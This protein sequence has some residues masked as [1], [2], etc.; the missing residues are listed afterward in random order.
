MQTFPA[1][2]LTNLLGKGNPKKESCFKNL[3]FMCPNLHSLFP[4]K[5]LVCKIVLLNFNSGCLG[6]S[7]DR[8]MWSQTR[9][10][11]TPAM[12]CFSENTTKYS[13]A[14]RKKLYIM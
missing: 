10:P 14:N 7:Y 9:I 2:D 6:L 11:Q 4:V 8:A 12:E 5:S 1:V 3:L 13:G